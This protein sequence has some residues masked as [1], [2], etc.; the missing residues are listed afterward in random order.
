MLD[1]SRL[2]IK[3]KVVQLLVA[4][5]QVRSAEALWDC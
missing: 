1:R 5:A 4:I 3:N 2:F